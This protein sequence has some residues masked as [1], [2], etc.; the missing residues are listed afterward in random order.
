MKKYIYK[1]KRLVKQVL[2]YSL[3]YSGVLLLIKNIAL[4]NK[5]II[6]TYHRVLP[7]SARSQSFSHAAIMVD[8][9]RF[10]WQLSFIKRHFNIINSTKLINIFENNFQP[11]SS[12]CL[13]T[14]DDGWEDNYIYAFPL[15]RK[16]SLTALIFTATDYIDSKELFWQEAMGHGIRQ[17]IDLNSNDSKKFLIKHNLQYLTHVRNDK[18]T[19]LIRDYVRKLKSMTYAELDEILRDIT[20]ILGDIDYADVDT[21][22]SSSQLKEMHKTGIEFGSHACSHKILTRL[23]N[24]IVK[25]ELS[26]SKRF[27]HDMLTDEI[28]TIAYPNGDY[29]SHL[30]EL[31]QAAGYRIGFGTNHGYVSLSDDKF[32]LKRININD[33]TATNRPIMLATILGIF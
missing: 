32:N 24:Q 7:Y 8:P 1:I 26:Q 21:F 12:S 17:L 10:D 9:G 28:D 29:N 25:N 27:L 3:Y 23:D 20:A 2:A 18:R 5:I 22:M 4:K 33:T 31:T 16:H 14:F 11:Q 19:D 30:G 13:I 15:L 6:L